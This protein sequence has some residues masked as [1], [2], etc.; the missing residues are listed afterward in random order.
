MY[1]K[2]SAAAGTIAQYNLIP[3]IHPWDYKGQNAEPSKAPTADLKDH[4]PSEK[5]PKSIIN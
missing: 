4:S 5:Q 2:G 3:C 1:E